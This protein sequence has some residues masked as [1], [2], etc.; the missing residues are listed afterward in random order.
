M[1]RTAPKAH[2]SCG[3]PLCTG[4]KM[5]WLEP[6]TLLIPAA[7]AEDSDA[8]V[9]AAA[10]DE[11]AE[12]PIAVGGSYQGEVNSTGDTDV[13]TVTLVA[14]QTY[15][16]SLR[17]GEA[18]QITDPYL[19]ITNALGI[20]VAN[21][22]D[23][24][25]GINSMI[26]YT[27]SVTGT[28]K[29]VAG[30]FDNGQP[31]LGLYTLDVL[32]MGTDSVPGDLTSNVTLTIGQDTFGFIETPGE[33]D[34]YKVTL[35]AGRLYTFEVAGGA[36]YNTNYLAVPPGEL[37]TK[38]SLYDAAGNLVAE[39]DDIN[40]SPVPGEGDISSAIGYSAAAS[41]T[42]YLRVEAYES[43]A[44]GGTGGYALQT[45][46]VDLTL[47][48]PT[49]AIDW[50]T[51]LP[52]T[53]V[54]V[55]FAGPGEVYDGVPSAG[56][57]DYEIQQAM[58]AF[59]TWADVTNLT[60]TRTMNANTATF[61]LVT[62]AD[63]N[64]L[65][66]FNPPGTTNAGV[67]V[68]AVNG[69]GW[70]RLGTDG[71]LEQGGY[72]W[73]TLIHEFGHGIG[74]AHPHDNGGTSD[75]MPGVT[76]P[77]GSYGVFDLNQGVYTTMSYNDG[78]QTHPDAVDGSPPGDPLTWGYQGGP[79]AFDIAAVQA[80]YG[81]D[82]D[83]N[84][85]NTVYV[86]AAANAPGTFWQTIWDVSGIDT[87]IHN[88]TVSALI[89]LTAATLDYS[90]TGAGVVSFVDG[91][92]GGYTIAGGV[93]I[94]NATGGSAADVLVGNAAANQLDGRG[95]ADS[96]VGRGGDDLY[97]ADDAGDVVL[98][99]S[100][101]G[102]DE[103]RT[104]AADYTI[105]GHVEKLTG[106]LAT[107][108]QTLRGNAVANILAGAAADNIFRLEQG[109]DDVATGGAGNDAFIFGA[110]LTAADQVDGGEGADQLGIQ[111]NYAMTFGA[112]N[113]V[114]IETLALLSG[115]DTR[116][117]DPGTNFYSYNLTTV[118]ANVEAGKQLRVNYNGLRVGEN[119]VFN[120]SA[121]NDGTFFVFA[122]KGDDVLTGGG[123]DDAFFFGA[124]GQFS[125]ADR[126][127][128]GAGRDQLGLRGN[129][130]VTFGA[131]TITS[132]ESLALLSGSDT[133]FGAAAPEFDYVITLH[134]DNI[135]PGQQLSVNAAQLRPGESLTFSAQF[136]TDGSV[137]VLGGQGNDS[138][139]GGGLGDF[140]YGGLGQDF[141]RGGPTDRVGWPGFDTYVYR[142]AAEST[143]TA[144]DTIASFHWDRD[145]IDL[146]GSG[147]VF[148]GTEVGKLDAATFDADIAAATAG[149]LTAPK[150][151][152]YFTATSGDMAGRHFL[153]VDANGVAGY[154]AG[155]DYVIEMLMPREA[156]P[157]GVPPDGFIV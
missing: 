137:R 5:D 146:P 26:S 60:F 85:G 66:Y 21:D 79:G 46:E 97:F 31:D 110:T 47:L 51:Q 77:F 53:T 80:K 130:T 40:F 75:I 62:T 112:M 123:K 99:K 16:I 58:L 86:L 142:A 68:F 39:N 144:F 98:E 131:T 134:N 84:A 76:G 101:E 104:S 113:L 67:G 48:N 103:I 95:G 147:Y 65:G 50:G 6:V 83:R 132:I 33:A 93:V 74:L 17:G 81:A 44:G 55:Y 143:S 126:I 109:G 9:T 35:T 45:S 25:T 128:G 90:P 14:G 29:I 78:W 120:G 127:D 3:C 19:S 42:Y 54:T 91:V 88:G 8:L 11:P 73:I 94:E 57:T 133:R 129:Y 59:Q 23:G 117:G 1:I 56:W 124:E 89:D 71:G 106:T 52:S 28:Y 155:D 27:P 107:G 15:M 49:D 139:V 152:A 64:Y 70:D 111:G 145:K 10:A 153:V 24:G 116:F 150:L 125:D 136:E 118:N 12:T 38:L 72:G 20:E 122:G 114:G 149:R 63:P 156:G 4:A 22:D 41:G 32:Q 100:G 13:Y 115:S 87:V 30:A 61:K 37:D 119:V 92:F 36:D 154:Q 69:T 2:F 108:T 34:V 82:P 102:N 138:I 18:G 141:M 121:E 43:D 148:T 157:L 151:A 140:L 96:M 135:A 105:A 7:T